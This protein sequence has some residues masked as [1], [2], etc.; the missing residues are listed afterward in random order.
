MRWKNTV[1][2]QMKRANKPNKLGNVHKLPYP[3][4]SVKLRFQDRM[5]DR[6]IESEW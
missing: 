2:Y 5:E 1:N 6:L 3:E 4:I